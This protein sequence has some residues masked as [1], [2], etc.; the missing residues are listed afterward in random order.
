M[1]TERDPRTRTVLSWLRD[2]A[3]ENAERVLLLALDEVDTTPQRRSWWPARRSTPMNTYARYAIAA[4]AVLMVAVVG[5]SLLPRTPGTGG[6]QTPVATAAATPTVA[7]TP[8]GI[9]AL[10]HGLLEAGAYAWYWS[11][12]PITFEVPAGWVGVNGEGVVKNSAQRT[13]V[14]WDVWRPDSLPVTH[15][16]ADAC[17]SEG[18]LMPV[19]PTVDDLVQALEEQA[20]S[21]VVVM[22]ETIGARPAK[23]VEIVQSASV[24]RSTCR[25]GSEGPHQIWADEAETAFYALRPEASGVVHIVDVAGARVVFTSAIGAEASPSDVGELERMIE[26]IE[27]GSP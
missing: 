18:Q 3:H 7:P 17:R 21:D 12:P 16:Y 26:S 23:R 9:P 4:A 25:Y 27:F 11:G 10:R 8:T 6:Q 5:Y 2:D 19:G 20:S 1:T 13:E 24:D 15:V 14:L 22:D